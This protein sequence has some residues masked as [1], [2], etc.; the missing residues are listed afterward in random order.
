MNDPKL[1][2]YLEA[3]T[4]VAVILVAIVVLSAFAWNFLKRG[5]QMKIQAGL[6]RGQK[7]SELPI[8]TND[9]ATQTLLVA[10]NTSCHYCN[11][12]VPFY[13][14]LAEIQHDANNKI[15]EIAM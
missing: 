15:L 6:Q 12:S 8:V 7:L 14:Q 2:N 4:N 5:Q 13:N 3:T 10:M 11:E 1:K 9:N